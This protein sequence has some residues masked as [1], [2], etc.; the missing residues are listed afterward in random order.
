MIRSSAIN[1]NDYINDNDNENDNVSF[2]LEN[3][4]D[5]INDNDNTN[6]NDYI[7]DNDKKKK[8]RTLEVDGIANYLVSKLNNPGAI[9]Y[10]RKIAW[11]LPPNIIFENL[12]KSRKGRQPARLFTWLCQTELKR[13]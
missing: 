10:Y 4:N 12:E 9:N 11:K 5:N 3:N 6:V 7:N 2:L 8:D 13:R 1:V